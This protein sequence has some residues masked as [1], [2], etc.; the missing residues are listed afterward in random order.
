ME[1]THVLVFSESSIIVKGLEIQLK[2]NNIGYLIKDPL[3]SGVLAGFGSFGKSV[4][5]Y[6]LQTDLDK[7]TPIIEAY[8]AEIN[9]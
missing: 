2:D 1:S 6:I 8:K 4:E 5:L 7:A 9:S 3:N